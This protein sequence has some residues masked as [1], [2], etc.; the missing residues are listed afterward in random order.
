MGRINIVLVSQ[1]IVGFGLTAT[2]TTKKGSSVFDSEPIPFKCRDK[3]NDGQ[4]ELRE[5]RKERRAK[6]RKNR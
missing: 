3:F 2:T 5:T 4:P 1:A 6:G